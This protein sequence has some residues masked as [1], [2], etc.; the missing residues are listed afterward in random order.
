GGEVHFVPVDYVSAA[1]LALSRDGGNTGRTFHIYNRSAL[2]LADCVEYLREYG[3]TLDELAWD[4][5]SE[6]V[7]SDPGNAM[8]PLF[9]AFEMMASD[10]SALYPRIDVSETES[11][12]SG[13]GIECPPLTREL[14]EKYVNFFVE[15]GYFP[16]PDGRGN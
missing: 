15:V 7:K 3:F 11:A 5:W 13:T 14:F 4:A 12:L 1:I 16:G 6:R 2:D 9:D 8:T 10:A